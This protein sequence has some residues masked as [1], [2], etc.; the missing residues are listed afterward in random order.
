MR[1]TGIFDKLRLYYINTYNT[2]T[3]PPMDIRQL[4]IFVE[5]ARAKNFRAAALQLGIAQ[6]AVTQRIRQLEENLG[7]K[8]FLRVN[9]GVELTPAGQSMLLDAEEILARTKGALEKA[10]QIRRGQLGTL[11]IG[12]G[13]SVMAE[14]KLPVLITRYGNDHR[15]VTLELLPGMTMEQLI[16]QVATRKT[17]VAFIRAPLPQLPQSLRAMP[18]DR[19]KLCVALPERHPLASRPRVSVGDIV[20]EKLLLPVDEIGLGL[21]SS[22]LSLFED[23][24]CEPEIGMRIANVNTILA[25]VDA[26][27][28]ISILP[29]TTVRSTRGITGV[30]LESADAWSD[31]V[32]V[33]R[34]GPLALHVEAF[35]NMVR[36]AYQS[37]L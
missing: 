15:E 6:P 4:A 16:E 2:K 9:R 32:L 30:P 12:F 26:G 33:V 17:D 19:S 24:G 22:A 36:Q 34:R 8:L 23:G 13:T 11:R 29:E 28:G 37:H 35:V 18:F 14:R 25:L 1:K 5:A 7:F 27:A 20:Q 31:S 10:H 3:S 21:S